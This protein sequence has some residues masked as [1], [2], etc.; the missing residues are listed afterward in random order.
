V[1]ASS[2]LPERESRRGRRVV[3]VTS[4]CF[5]ALHPGHVEL[6]RVAASLGDK[7]VVLMNSDRSISRLKGPERPVYPEEDREKMLRA[8]RYVDDVVV[9]SEDDPLDALRKL[10]EKIPQHSGLFG[11]RTVFSYYVKGD[12]WRGREI[13]ETAFVESVGARLVFVPRTPHSTTDVVRRFSKRE[14]WEENTLT[15]AQLEELEGR[16]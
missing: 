7:L 8:I 5:D 12:D 6:L 15:G 3:V 4:G 16:R 11:V 10:Y 13:P 14:I 2:D 9:F 1:T